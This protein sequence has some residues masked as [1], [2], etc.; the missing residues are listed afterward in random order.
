M[1]AE[2]WCKATKTQQEEAGSRRNDRAKLHAC[3][4]SWDEL[5][6]VDVG[7]KKSD[8]TFIQELAATAGLKQAVQNMTH[9]DYVLI[10]YSERA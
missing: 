8:E 1:R 5:D 6:T 3:I 9:L 10:K 4:C 7:I 2:G